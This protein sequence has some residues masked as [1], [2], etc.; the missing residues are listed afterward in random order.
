VDRA[1][2]TSVD[3][4]IADRLAEC[5]D[6]SGTLCV[7]D[8]VINTGG[9]F[10]LPTCVSVDGIEGRCT[11]TAIPEVAAGKDMLPQADC[12]A[13]ERCVPCFDPVD[14]S[15]TG[16]C[17]L[18]CDAG[19]NQEPRALA[20]CADGN[21]GR[22]VPTDSIPAADRETFAVAEC[23]DA[24]GAG[25]NYSCVPNQLLQNGPWL[26][27]TGDLPFRGDYVGS[28]LN[29]EIMDI[30]GSGFFD[31]DTCV[32]M[33]QDFRCTP[34]AVEDVPTGAPGCDALYPNLAQ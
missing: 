32:A 24:P 17:D 9:F 21:L 25:A 30:G 23:E 12:N 34:C 31:R 33:G 18:S 5:A 7:P 4:S 8:A 16:L 29:T 14:A 28:C 26:A 27:C 11:S 20:A 1:L 19:P 15:P 10:T 3:A 6:N 13:T 2:V 22:C